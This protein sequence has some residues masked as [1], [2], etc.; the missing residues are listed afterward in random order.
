MSVNKVAEK[1]GM[2]H[3]G[4]LQIESGERSPML[5]NVIKIAA[6]LEVDLSDLFSDE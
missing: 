5:R 1:A 4:I 6:A 2:S 3:V